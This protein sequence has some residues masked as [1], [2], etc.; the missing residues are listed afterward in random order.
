M[1]SDKLPRDSELRLLGAPAKACVFMLP[2]LSDPDLP[3]IG[4]VALDV[5]ALS[6]ETSG[7]TDDDDDEEEMAWICGF[8]SDLDPAKISFFSR[9]RLG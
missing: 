1:V 5:A 6:E 9:A 4:V 3:S 2:E 7:A 8:V